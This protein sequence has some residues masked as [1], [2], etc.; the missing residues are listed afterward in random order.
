[1]TVMS[2]AGQYA[3]PTSWYAPMMHPRSIR[4][5]YNYGYWLAFY[6]FKDLEYHFRQHGA[7]YEKLLALRR[8]YY[9]C[10]WSEF[11]P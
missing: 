4:E 3:L 8:A 7:P 2:V 1:M 10:D 9:S 11:L 6:L 5:R